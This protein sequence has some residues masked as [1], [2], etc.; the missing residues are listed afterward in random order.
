M[1]LLLLF[2]LPL[3]AYSQDIPKGAEGIELSTDLPDSTLFEQVGDFLTDKDY[4]IQK[5]DAKR[6]TI[7]TEHKS[8]T[9]KLSMRVL[10]TIKDSKAIFRGQWSAQAMGLTFT[11]EPVRYKGLANSAEKGAFLALDE[12]AN[13]LSVAIHDSSIQY[14]PPKK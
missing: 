7:V 12:L 13:D 3:F 6:G 1:K 14:I 5:E 11:N 2:L 8:L 9:N 10:V 4:I